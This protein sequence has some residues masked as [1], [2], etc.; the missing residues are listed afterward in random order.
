MGW[1]TAAVACLIASTVACRFHAVSFVTVPCGA[2]CPEAADATGGEGAADPGGD[3]VPDCDSRECG[4]DPAC[5]TSCGAC[6]ADMTCTPAGACIFQLCDPGV[7]CNDFNPCTFNDRCT[8]ERNCVGEPGSDCD[9]DAGPCGAQRECDGAGGC[10]VSYPSAE[11][12]CNDGDH[13]TSGDHC[14]GGLCV[15]ETRCRDDDGC[16]GPGSVLCLDEATTCGARRQCAGDGECALS[17]PPPGT[18]CDDNDPCTSNDHCT[19][20]GS[21]TGT[22][23]YDGTSCTQAIGATVDCARLPVTCNFWVCGLTGTCVSG[24]PAGECTPFAREYSCSGP[25]CC[26]WRDCTTSC[27]WGSWSLIS[28]CDAACPCS[29]AACFCAS[30]GPCTA[31]GCS[32]C[33]AAP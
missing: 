24:G 23:C 15:G 3:C 18:P 25:G 4:P 12:T 7:G 31:A 29:P 22:R 14:L 16:S 2:D 26:D 28:L 8:D 6:D 13:C 21:C 17:F 32:E 9:D 30:G 10:I 33:C 11:I 5:G 19:G 1:R 20:D 27:T